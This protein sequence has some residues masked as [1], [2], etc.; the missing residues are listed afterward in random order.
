MMSRTSTPTTIK[1]IARHLKLSM[2]TVSYAL[3]GG[4]R[5]VSDDVK[6]R[7]LAAALELHYRPNRIAK[8]MVTRKTHTIGVV[9]ESVRHDA[10]LSPY[11]HLCLNALT[12]ASEEM[13]YDLLVFTRLDAMRPEAIVHALLDGRV[14]G[15]VFLSP[16]FDT[17][18]VKTIAD[19]G[20]P[21]AVISRKLDF[22]VPQFR[23]D[24]CAGTVMALHHLWDLGHRRIGHIAGPASQFDAEERRTTYEEFMRRRGVS[25]LVEVG[26]FDTQMSMEA[27]LH[28]LRN[29]DL[30]AIY[31][32]NDESAIGVLLAA[33]H[34]GLDVPGELSVVGFDDVPVSRLQRPALTSVRQPVDRM[35]RDAVRMVASMLRHDPLPQP[36][37]YPT[38]LVIRASSGPVRGTQEP[39]LG[40]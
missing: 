32:G 5:N 2:S 13:G 19:A 10:L 24:N 20:L 29:H 4:P 36:P 1:D 23:A 15:A 30:T 33:N 37:I 39:Q 31:A 25:P 28:L 18:L 21:C 26:N 17:G 6:Q 11:H 35:A 9:P 3:N 16:T 34:L 40:S 22:R 38:E 12:C 8:S 27:A 7:V 14:D